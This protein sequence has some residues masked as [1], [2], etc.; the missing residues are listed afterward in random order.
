M[1]TLEITQHKIAAAA[2]RAGRE[3]Q[4]VK[5]VAVSKGQPG[6]KIRAA[7]AAGLR[8]FGENYAQELLEK[9]AELGG[10]NIEWHFLGHLQT[11]KIGKILPVIA[12]LHSLDSLELAGAVQKRAQKPLP[13]LLE[14]KLAQDAAKTGL[15]PQAALDLIPKLKE[16]SN[17]DLRGL[18]TI[19]PWDPDPEKSRPAFRELFTLLKTVNDRYLYGKPLT[20]LSMGM[21]HDFE[22]AIEEGATMV[23]IGT[24][25]FGERK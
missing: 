18:M 22:V 25:I 9:Q 17:I 2:K 21:S 15:S 16:F 23:R 3:P 6:D 14:I 13:C 4:G 24:A 1:H 5:L 12:W 10:L 8:A 7:Y 11:N 20:E 19:P